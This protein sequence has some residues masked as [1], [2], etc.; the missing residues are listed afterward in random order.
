MGDQN[1]QSDTWGWMPKQVDPDPGAAIQ[2]CGWTWG[3]GYIAGTTSPTC[4]EHLEAWPQSRATPGGLRA[5]GYIY[6]S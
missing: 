2:H 4:R 3:P 5:R 6:L 1:L